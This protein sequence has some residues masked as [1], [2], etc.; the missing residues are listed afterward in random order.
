MHSQYANLSS[1]LE[2]ANGKLRAD[3]HFW[4]LYQLVLSCPL[5]CNPIK[6]R[7]VTLTTQ[8]RVFRIP[9]LESTRTFV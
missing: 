8:W 2:G 7:Q 5:M 4:H 3:L 1:S 6:P 9:S